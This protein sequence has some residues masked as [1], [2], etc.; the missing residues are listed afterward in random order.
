MVERFDLSI[1][2]EML[3]GLNSEDINDDLAIFDRHSCFFI[4]MNQITS[5][6]YG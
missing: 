2:R 6:N 3:L 5:G 4:M 1:F